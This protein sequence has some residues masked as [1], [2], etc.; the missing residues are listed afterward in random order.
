M[1][2][3]AARLLT[4]SFSSSP[5]SIQLDCLGQLFDWLAGWLTVGETLART[6][7][8]ARE[9]VVD[10]QKRARRALPVRMPGGRAVSCSGLH[11]CAAP[12]VAVEDTVAGGDP[13][14]LLVVL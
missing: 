8:C 6:W 3:I 7:R 4:A 12:M 11:L 2:T 13:Q 9:L 5:G 10:G 14:R 1:G